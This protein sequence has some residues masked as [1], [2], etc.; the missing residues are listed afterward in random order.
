MVEVDP[1][2]DGRTVERWATALSHRNHCVP[3]YW[4]QGMPG[5]QIGGIV[6]WGLWTKRRWFVYHTIGRDPSHCAE[7]GVISPIIELE[8]LKGSYLAQ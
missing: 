2:W 1:W 4:R 8:G 6:G 3:E 7:F 5:Y